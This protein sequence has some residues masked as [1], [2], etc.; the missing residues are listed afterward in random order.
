MYKIF[1]TGT[2]AFANN[3]FKFVKMLVN[4]I[5]YRVNAL[6]AFNAH[7]ICLFFFVKH[8]KIFLSRHKYVHY[9]RCMFFNKSGKKCLLSGKITVK[10]TCRNSCRFDDIAKRSRFKTFFKKLL[11]TCRQYIL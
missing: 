3:Q 7:M 4:I 6:S 10:C 11:F 1:I 5:N 2:F 8:F 9:S